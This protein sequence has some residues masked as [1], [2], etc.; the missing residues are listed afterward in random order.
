MRILI[1]GGTGFIGT[2]LSNALL[3]AGH[4]L[5]LLTRQSRHLEHSAHES[6]SSIADLDELEAQDR[7]DAII[8]LAGEP[9][10]AKRWSQARKA[11][12]LDSRLK[13]TAAL[14][15][16]C[17]RAQQPP[18]CLISASAVGYYGD[19]GQQKVDEATQPQPD[20]G[21]ELCARWEALAQE[22]QQVGVRVCIARIGLVIGADGGFLQRMLLPF[23]LGLGGPMGDGQQWMSWIH[24]DDL[25][26]LLSWLMTNPDCSGVYNA[27]APN[28]VTN[29]KF[30]KTLAHCL[31]RPAFMR[32]PAFALRLAFGEM[33]GLLLTGQ[34]VLPQRALDEAFTFEHPQLKEALESVL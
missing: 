24:L 1:T 7:F 25:V 31:N 13:T 33:A 8:N 20:F 27:T 17:R 21:H 4:R 12:L 30:S 22:A 19:Q 9:I 15:A 14:L 16:Y 11:A 32:T 18:D 23:K 5:V 3:A 34:R 10:A 26:R 29:D 6:L 2:A 28:P